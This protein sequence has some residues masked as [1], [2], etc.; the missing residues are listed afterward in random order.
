MSGA[1]VI[2]VKYDS[3]L[4]YYRDEFNVIVPSEGKLDKMKVLYLL[5]GLHG[6]CHD[7]ITYTNITRL[8][9]TYKVA[10]VCPNA[11]NSFYTD[12][13][14]GE[15]FYTQLTTEFLQH[16]RRIFGFS[17]KRQDNMIAGLSM[18][19][20]GAFK[21]AFNNPH[22]SYGAGSFS[23]AARPRQGPS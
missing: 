12:M 1:S 23:G 11:K 7:W 19:G 5:H 10:V 14:Y 2:N 15:P 13:V 18:G 6:T 9:E 4:L 16:V 21:I 8:S 22:R 17:D 3:N 20:Y